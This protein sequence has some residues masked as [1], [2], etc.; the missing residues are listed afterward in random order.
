MHMRQTVRTRSLP[1]IL[2]C[3]ARPSARLKSIRN[4]HQHVHAFD[5]PAEQRLAF[6]LLVVAFWLRLM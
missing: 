1:P 5:Q 6:G 4:F 3:R 2:M